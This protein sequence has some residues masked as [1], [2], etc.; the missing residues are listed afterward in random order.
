MEEIIFPT[1][2]LLTVSAAICWSFWSRVT[3]GS[4]TFPVRFKVL[5]IL[6]RYSSSMVTNRRENGGPGKRRRRSG[7]V[8]GRRRKRS[9][10]LREGK[11][12]YGAGDASIRDFRE[13]LE[14]ELLLINPKKKK[15]TYI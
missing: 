7:R 9:P 4:R 1:K 15:K 14:E 5:Q 6:A 12:A 11:D 10:Q 8:G 13:T 3:V 2:Q